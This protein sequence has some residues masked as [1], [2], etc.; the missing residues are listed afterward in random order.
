ML[1]QIGGGGPSFIKK[2]TPIL[3][4]WGN[5]DI[6]IRAAKPAPKPWPPTPPSLPLPLVDAT[7]SELLPH[8]APNP[9]SPAPPFPSLPSLVW[10]PWSSVVVGHGAVVSGLIA[11]VVCGRASRGLRLMVV[12]APAAVSSGRP[13]GPP[14]SLRRSGHPAVPVFPVVSLTP[15]RSSSARTGGSSAGSGTSTSHRLVFDRWGALVVG[16]LLACCHLVVDRSCRWPWPTEQSA[17]A[18]FYQV[19]RSIL[20]S[21]LAAI[22]Q[23][24]QGRAAN[25]LS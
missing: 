20:L 17:P 12:P 8:D 14:I 10:S 13:G 24:S 9:M 4:A 23:G 2:K 7:D 5:Q 11:L 18:Q 19:E 15:N 3:G 16:R 22:F 1:N 6:Q 21:S 25:P